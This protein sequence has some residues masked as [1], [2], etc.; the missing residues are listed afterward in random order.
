MKIQAHFEM[1]NKCCDSNVKNVEKNT[2][3]MKHSDRDEEL[4]VDMCLAL[5]SCGVFVSKT[6]ANNQQ[7]QEGSEL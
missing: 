7:Y 1:L 3:E 4:V 2:G 6:V 5:P